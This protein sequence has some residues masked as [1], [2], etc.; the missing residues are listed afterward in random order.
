MT[1]VY[2]DAG[3]LVKLVVDEEGGDDDVPWDGCD[4]AVV[5]PSGVPGGSGR[6]LAAAARGMTIS[7]LVRGW[8]ADRLAVEAL[9]PAGADPTVWAAT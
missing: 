8:I 3:A 6:A 9:H 1:L 7:E 5:E 2:F 4:A